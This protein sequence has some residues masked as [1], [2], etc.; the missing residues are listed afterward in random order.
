M[1][2]T[3][4]PGDPYFIARFV[5]HKATQKSPEVKVLDSGQVGICLY[6]RSEQKATVNRMIKEKKLCAFVL[7]ETWT[8]GNLT[9]LYA[10]ID[11]LD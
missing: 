4:K 5:S 11:F 6:F 10:A 1:L 9:Y 7:S 8:A 3:G 2:F